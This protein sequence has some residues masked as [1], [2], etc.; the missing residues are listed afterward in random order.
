M[1]LKKC[2][3]DS[4]LKKH[5]LILEY[6]A[7]DTLNTKLDEIILKFLDGILEDLSKQSK[8]E[9]GFQVSDINFYFK[10]LEEEELIIKLK[11]DEQ[12]T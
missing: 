12:T 4:L 3:Y 2:H 5:N 11:D 6:R 10:E 8:S 7:R 1:I 9:H